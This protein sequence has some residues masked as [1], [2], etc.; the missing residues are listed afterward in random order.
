ME[1][2]LSIQLADEALELLKKK[3]I[4]KLDLCSHRHCLHVLPQYLCG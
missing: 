1:L 4:L 3:K 2:Q